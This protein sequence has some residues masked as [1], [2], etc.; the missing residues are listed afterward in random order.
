MFASRNNEIAFFSTHVPIQFAQR[1]ANRELQKEKINRVSSLR[2]MQIF[3]ATSG[4]RSKSSL[5]AGA[6][7]G[8]HFCPRKQNNQVKITHMM[9]TET[10]NQPNP[11]HIYG[12]QLIF[13]LSCLAHPHFNLM[14]EKISR[15]RLNYFPHP[16]N[17][18]N[19]RG[20]KYFLWSAG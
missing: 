19:L 8:G 4:R 7:S 10:I 15:A 18:K 2:A 11:A 16:S 13:F 3:L 17:L 6:E 20:Y 14:V 9:H 12:A 1:C 5:L